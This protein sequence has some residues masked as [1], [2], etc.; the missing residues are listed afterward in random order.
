MITKKKAELAVKSKLGY[1]VKHYTKKYNFTEEQS[2]C[3]IRDTGIVDILKNN[4]SRLF[5]E[6]AELLIDA[7]DIFYSQSKNQMLDY[8]KNNIGG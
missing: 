3:Y 2:Y 1:L 4:D 8:L 5:L 7:I 6:P